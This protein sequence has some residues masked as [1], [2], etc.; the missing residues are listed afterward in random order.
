MASLE[1][2]Q[3][4]RITEEAQ[5][6]V[7]STMVEYPTR[8][9]DSDKRICTFR[10]SDPTESSTD[11]EEPFIVTD[12]STIA[13]V[14]NYLKGFFYIYNREGKRYRRSQEDVLWVVGSQY[15]Y[16]P[17]D[18][19]YKGCL[20]VRLD[21]AA[22]SVSFNSHFKTEKQKPT[23]RSLYDNF[24]SLSFGE[25]Y[26]V[27]SD[28]VSC[29]EGNS[30]RPLLENWMDDNF[31][32]HAHWIITNSILIDQNKMILDQLKGTLHN[33][34][35]E[36]LKNYRLSLKDKRTATPKSQTTPKSKG[37]KSVGSASRSD[38]IEIKSGEKYDVTAHSWVEDKR[39]GT[40]TPKKEDGSHDIDALRFK[41]SIEDKGGE[42]VRKLF[43]DV[44]N[45]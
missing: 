6:N 16:H 11:D 30:L 37:K 14:D 31:F 10:Y 42:V 12:T 22:S 2:L 45:S 17:K 1:E 34:K 44:A 21:R 24:Q 13:K 41:K 32:N 43:N 23:D 27:H 29:V 28:D 36:V 7:E 35:E 3:Q 26:P 38:D 25:S 33:M 40:W 20:V 19:L 15:A 18:R 9:R 8:I 5:P 39:N 4:L